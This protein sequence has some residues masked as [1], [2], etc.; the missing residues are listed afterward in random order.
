MARLDPREIY[1]TSSTQ[2]AIYGLGGVVRNVIAL[3]VVST[4]YVLTRGIDALSSTFIK[5][6]FA[7]GDAGAAFVNALFAD[8]AAALAGAWEFMLTSL[9]TGS[10]SFFGPLTPLVVLGVILA[11]Y[12]LYLWFADRYN[13]DLPSTGDIPGVGLDESGADDEQ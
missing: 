4:G 1:S 13:I 10:W 5:P 8:P 3:L 11:G 9:T 2:T 7:L 12:A 6:L